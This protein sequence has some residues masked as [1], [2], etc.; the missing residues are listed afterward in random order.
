MHLQS[1]KVCL[2]LDS[3]MAHHILEAQLRS[4]QL[5]YLPPWTRRFSAL[6]GCT[7]VDASSD[8]QA[9]AQ[10]GVKETKITAF[11]EIEVV[12]ASC[13]V[14]GC[15]IVINCFSHTGVEAP[16]A[17]VASV[18]EGPNTIVRRSHAVTKSRFASWPKWQ[19]TSA[20]KTF[21]VPMPA[22]MRTQ[23]GP[24]MRKVLSSSLPECQRSRKMRMTRNTL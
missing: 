13:E 15:L 12:A 6:W 14:R 16:N 17:K 1:R 3:C 24:W 18:S 8:G 9:A 2:L 21:F 19:Q 23:R 20:S 7:Y 5:F 10:L 4:A 22:R 11:M